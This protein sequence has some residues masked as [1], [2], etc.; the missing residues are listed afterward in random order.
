[1]PSTHSATITYFATFIPLACIYLPLH[2]SLPAAPNFRFLPP[3]IVLPW[4]TLIVMSRV[5]LG[6]HTW[7]QVAVGISY[8]AVFAI[9]WFKLWVGGLNNHGNVFEQKFQDWLVS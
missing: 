8:G 9:C 1:M 3:L 4:A 5:W 7:P 2:P 6:H